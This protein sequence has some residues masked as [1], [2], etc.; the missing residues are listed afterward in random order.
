[1]LT[2]CTAY[3]HCLQKI[4]IY[5]MALPNKITNHV[6]FMPCVFNIPLTWMNCS[7]TDLVKLLQTSSEVWYY[8]TY[9][10]F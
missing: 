6:L 9:I 2:E 7:H 3:S 4:A 10:V 8:M 1:M 5:H